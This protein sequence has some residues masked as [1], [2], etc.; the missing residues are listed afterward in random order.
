MTHSTTTR[1]T[2]TEA[3][4]RPRLLPVVIPSIAFVMVSLDAL[5]VVT[6][7]PS[8]HGDLGGR[9][10]NLQWLITS[11]NLTFAAGIIAAAAL[12]DRFG[13][14]R[15]F[16]AGLAL[17]TA[18][19]AACAVAPDLSLLIGFRAFQGVGAAVVTPLG[20]TLV[21]AAFPAERRGAVV[22]IWGGIA[23]LGIAAGPL[24]GGAVTEGLDWHW[25]FWVNVPIGLLAILGSRRVL[26]DSRGPAR[27]LDLPG[28]LLAGIGVAV[29]VWALVQAPDAGWGTGRT[30]GALATGAALVAAFLGWEARTRAP[31]IPLG[32]FRRAQFSA[33]ALANLL[34][35]GAVF[36]AAY[37]TSQF[38]QIARGDGPLDA[39]L[40]MLPWTATPLVVAPLAGRLFDRVGARV[41]AVPGL[42]AQAAGFLWIVGLAGTQASWGA[43]V[44]PLVISGVGVS[45][46]LPALPAASLNAAPPEALGQASGVVNT[47]QRFGAVLAV[48]VATAVFDASGA[49][50]SPAAATDGY[51]PA[52]L[53]AA[54]F[55]AVGAV[56]A[57]WAAGRPSR[58][59]WRPHDRTAHDRRAHR[60][61]DGQRGLP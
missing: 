32:L 58:A 14:L 31:M 28:M 59:Q 24:V 8:I 38:F 30:L 12:G 41:L 16:L 42:L 50:T 55:S 47:L 40:H 5:V 36:A 1:L 37:L 7:L 10:A 61:G 46:A 56:V 45:L 4:A 34:M 9:P 20:L 17:F 6:A 13:R 21:T 26:T 33:A 49:L 3:V 52:M 23:G 48:A 53:V 43:Y 29:L 27:P 19:S 35:V 44:A 60:R 18:A 22:G 2:P 39:G 15:V 25:V 11:Y 57:L 51:R 54:A